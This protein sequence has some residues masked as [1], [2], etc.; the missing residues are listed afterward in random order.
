MCV[1]WRNAGRG[2][3]VAANDG[4]A[5]V[6]RD[7]GHTGSIERKA[8]AF[9]VYLERAIEHPPESVWRMLTEPD[10]LPRWL[11]PGSLELFPG[12]A[13]HID[14]PESGA[15]IDSRIRAL[16]PPRLLEYSWS[17]GDEPERPL[18]WQL[19]STGDGTRLALTLRLPGD[20]DAAK[21]AAGWDAHLEMLLAALEGVPI[22][23]P[24]DHFLE[25]RAR[26]RAQLGE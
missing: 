9:E 3:G 7:C 8:D 10:A 2:G 19:V 11:A 16:D 20:E 17:S 14:F 15:T 4:E 26:Y 13:V 12:G 22:R 18:R 1:R 21:S 25:A 6:N 24:V 23:F 5:V